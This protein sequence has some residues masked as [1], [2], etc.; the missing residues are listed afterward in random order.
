MTQYFTLTRSMHH[1]LYSYSMF[2]STMRSFLLALTI[3]TMMTIVASSLTD[4]GVGSVPASVYS[5]NNST[6]QDAH[7]RLQHVNASLSPLSR[8]LTREEA[9]FV[10]HAWLSSFQSSS[11]NTRDERITAMEAHAGS[12]EHTTSQQD[13]KK[14]G[15]SLRALA[16]ST[17]NSKYWY[18]MYMLVDYSCRLCPA[19]RRLE[20]QQ[21]QDEVNGDTHVSAAKANEAGSR[22]DPHQKDPPGLNHEAFEDLFC[23]AIKSGPYSVL[24]SIETC[25]IY[26]ED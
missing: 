18:Y 20:Q 3:M 16:T 21:Q 9:D 17:R 23:S 22:N 25:E 10:T 7:Y 5:N 13:T 4:E 15:G 14:K 24:H 19:N 12:C 8:N 2:Y 1:S 26:F 6:S 11:I